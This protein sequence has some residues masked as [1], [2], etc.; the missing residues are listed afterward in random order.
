LTPAA[1][2]DSKEV[3]LVISDSGVGISQDML[4]RVFDLFTQDDRTAHRSHTGLGVGLAL[5][6]RLIEL[7]GG[8]I[9]AQSDGAGRGST[10]TMRMPVSNRIA[11]ARPAA[12]TPVAP[13]ISRRVVVIDDNPSAAR[14][15]QRLVTVLGGECQIAHDGET[16]LACIRQLRPDFVILDIGMPRLDGYETCRRIRQEFG[17]D[18]MI[19]ALTGWGQERD[20]QR[21][22]RAG[23]NVH[24]TKPAEPLMLEAMLAGHREVPGSNGASD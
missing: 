1:G 18:I 10:F 19:V 21:A 6:R 17:P 20:K 13:R 22:M 12:A 5:A 3:A 8:S 7:H 2:A 24:L 14:A 16:G 11:D 9:E 23:F 15:I 4:P